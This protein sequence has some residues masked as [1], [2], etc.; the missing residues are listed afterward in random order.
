MSLNPGWLDLIEPAA[1]SAAVFAAGCLAVLALWRRSAAL[2][3]GV[4]VLTFSIALILP[5]LAVWLPQRWHVVEMAPPAMVESPV[6]AEPAMTPLPEPDFMPPPAAGPV[7]VLREIPST[8]AGSNSAIPRR[9]MS[10][11]PPTACLLLWFAGVILLSGGAGW[12][13][14]RLSR[15]WRRCLPLTEVRLQRLLDEA[16]EMTHLRQPPEARI[17]ADASG[18]MVWGIL[19]PKLVLPAEAA[20]WSDDRLRMVLVHECLHLSRRDPAVLSLAHFSLAL[21]WFNP[22]AW[23]AM[24]RLRI[25]QEA[26]CD[27]AVL[28]RGIS[29]IRYAAELLELAA[30][31]KAWPLANAMKHR[32][33]LERRIRRI[34]SRSVDRKPTTRLQSVM[35]GISAVTAAACLGIIGA[36]EV[37]AAPG[38]RGRILDRNGTVLAESGGHTERSYPFA[39]LASHVLGYAITKENAGPLEGKLGM[40]ARFDKELAAGRDVVLTL[41][42]RV[43]SAVE[44]VLAASRVGRGGVVV[45]DPANG[46]LLAAAS[47]PSFDPGLFVPRPTREHFREIMEDPSAPILN[48][49]VIAQ[50]PGS[51][52]HLMVALAASRAGLVDE[53]HS[54]EGMLDRRV[55]IRCWIHLWDNGSH[56]TLD[57]DGALAGACHPYF[58]RLAGSGGIELLAETG[59]L[60]GLGESTGTFTGE[61][62]GVLPSPEYLADTYGEADWTEHDTYMTAIGQGRMTATPLQLACFAAAIANGGTVFTPRLAQREPARVRFHL[63]DHG[64]TAEMIRQLQHSLKHNVSAEDGLARAARSE[65]ISIAGRTASSQTIRPGGETLQTE[66]IGWFIGYAPAD[67][68]RHAF[69]VMIEGSTGKVAARLARAIAE[70]LAADLP[71]AEARPPAAGHLEWVEEVNE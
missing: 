23:F 45:I 33:D 8:L 71:E 57:L 1:K 21:N 13:A 27:G 69:A 4:W 66:T 44:E 59:R 43:Q 3:H 35:I 20:H 47:V 62:S 63:P 12:G 56:G 67:E 61:Q 49:T 25:E 64:V 58:C 65:E 31:E 28:A 9:E 7:P 39:A 37:A 24:S 55:P 36:A 60:M 26:A 11:S 18:P 22:L 48:R 50:P 2:R 29:P 30:P 41:D 6:S 15:L 32:G 34:L 68:P 5:F 10:I 38:F 52:M 51:S 46:D 40:E 17:A 16:V 70:R 54:C 19:K 53:V 42:A 14:F